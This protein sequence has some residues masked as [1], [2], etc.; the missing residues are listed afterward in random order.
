MVL[1]MLYCFLI[2]KAGPYSLF[3]KFIYALLQFSLKS[4]I[5]VTTVCFISSNYF[6][7]TISIHNNVSLR[8]V[9]HQILDDDFHKKALLILIR[10]VYCAKLWMMLLGTWVLKY[11]LRQFT[12]AWSASI[13][14][15]WK[16]EMF[17][18]H[19]YGF[20]SPVVPNLWYVNKLLN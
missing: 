16:A 3:S 1:P 4:S 9:L 12:S 2:K 8:S 5:H 17:A 15:F 20:R 14:S 11:T 19:A 18:L 13:F 10:S 7:W 6:L